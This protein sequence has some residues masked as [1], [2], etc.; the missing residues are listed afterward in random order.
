MVSKRIA[1]K[2]KRTSNTPAQS[3][4]R[5]TT[6]LALTDASEPY[7]A[8]VSASEVF[9]AATRILEDNGTRYLVE[10]EGIDPGTG[11][12]YEPTWEPHNFVTL[13]L[14]ADWKKAIA[15]QSTATRR[16]HN[17][18]QSFEEAGS[19]VQFF[20]ESPET[21]TF[22]Q[23]QPQ[24]SLT[25][26]FQDPEQ[27]AC[28]SNSGTSYKCGATFPRQN[29][30]SLTI[31]KMTTLEETPG[32]NQRD[33][34]IADNSG[35]TNEHLG[36]PEPTALGSRHSLHA[37]SSP[38]I[39]EV[40]SVGH[41]QLSS[42]PDVVA[43]LQDAGCE[44]DETPENSRQE[45]P[46]PWELASRE[47]QRA[48][49]CTLEEKDSPLSALLTTRKALETQEQ[50]EMPGKLEIL[51]AMSSAPA[52]EAVHREPELQAA[53]KAMSS[54]KRSSDHALEKA[55][56][57]SLPGGSVEELH[58][59]SVSAE[60]SPGRLSKDGWIHEKTAIQHATAEPDMSD[61]PSGFLARSERSMSLS[62][63]QSESIVQHRRTR[64]CT[65][66]IAATDRAPI[67]PP[68]LSTQLGLRPET[69]TTAGQAFVKQDVNAL[70]GSRNAKTC[71]LPAAVLTVCARHT[72]EQN[73]PLEADIGVLRDPTTLNWSVREPEVV[74]EWEEQV[75][76]ANSMD[77]TGREQTD[78]VA[79]V[80][81]SPKPPSCEEVDQNSA[82]RRYEDGCRTVSRFTSPVVE[83]VGTY[84]TSPSEELRST[85][86][87]VDPFSDELAV[88][89][90]P[91]REPS[92]T[93][94]CSSSP[95]N[96]KR[97]HDMKL[98]PQHI[99]PLVDD[100]RTD[101]SS[102]D[103][104]VATKPM[105]GAAHVGPRRN[106]PFMKRVKTGCATCRR[107]KK[108]CDEAKPECDNCTRIG[109]TC[110]GYMDK[111]TLRKNGSSTSLP[112][113]SDQAPKPVDTH[114]PQSK[115]RRCNLADI[116]NNEPSLGSD[117]SIYQEPHA[118]VQRAD[119]NGGVAVEEREYRLP[120]PGRETDR[121]DLSRAS[122][123]REQP[124][125]YRT[126]YP[127]VPVHVHE[128]DVSNED[129][130]AIHPIQIPPLAYHKARGYDQP[131][132]NMG[133]STAIPSALA[134]D[135]NHQKTQSSR[136]SLPAI[137]D[138]ALSKPSL[139][140]NKQAVSLPKTEKQKML[141]GEPFMPYDT[142]LVDD[143]RQCAAMLYHFNKTLDV[144]PE[145]V[146]DMRERY[147]RAAID[148][149][150][151][152]PHCG[153]GPGSGRLGSNAH[154]V[155]PFH[156]DYGYNVSIGDNVVIGPS[157]RLLDSANIS[158]GRNTRIG[159]CVIITTL[160]APTDTEASKTSCSLEVARDVYIGENVYMGDCCVVGAG[161]RVGNSA[162]IRSGSLVVCDVPPNSIVCGNPADAYEAG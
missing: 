162:I 113:L 78:L 117:H 62:A 97:L 93:A 95:I 32:W 99:Q 5:R 77:A 149:A 128:R 74:R 7:R 56:P 88:V 112:S 35:H 58:L 70:A 136:S 114:Q 126:P 101:R 157:S 66:P 81:L 159:A 11:R 75:R 36:A 64:A 10:W 110:Q 54:T 138:T 22:R 153:D 121:H 155:T 140:Y 124:Y 90:R 160:E 145:L 92:V 16:V 115:P 14:E 141:D 85:L 161:V 107:R 21:V 13:A 34:A 69:K 19:R 23:S 18:A 103:R 118:P 73:K 40:G 125:P 105:D 71:P 102:V 127:L 43:K 132:H 27:T 12:P 135:A 123:P 68:G 33:P 1:K 20:S 61:E 109:I 82:P 4:R 80:S 91:S 24:R 41:V 146:Q 120:A 15:A 154:V 55:T 59:A 148:A 122:R 46:E 52:H 116:L 156:C 44:E 98:A 65:L 51:E 3:K 42:H 139:C 79:R 67:V 30:A 94:S 45:R 8:H 26:L 100:G 63:K 17:Q 83:S 9:W 57:F 25:S 152:R 106:K 104:A 137:T 60:R 144:M 6:R 72:S 47:S 38:R 143:R 28:V 131:P 2:R 147:F 150:C 151:T 108:K 142:Q 49:A 111:M 130:R 86:E 158:I 39:E 53:S 87:R 31:S 37:Q 133:L 96:Q 129:P 84:P 48:H 76:V 119:A 134:S 50:Q 89:P 29:N